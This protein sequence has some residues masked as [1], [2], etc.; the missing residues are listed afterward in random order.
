MTPTCP[1]DNTIDVDQSSFWS[2][3]N[4]NWDEHRIGWAIAGGCAMLTVL[5]SMVS[6]LGHC[7]NYTKPSEQRQILRILYMPPVYAVISFFS[8]RYFR[9]YTYYSL[10]ETA[11]EAITLSAFLLLLI[12]FVADTA[13]GRDA[14][15]AIERKGKRS[16]PIPFCCWK[17][18][19]TKPYFM[20]TVKWSV[21][22]YVIFRPAVSIAGIVCEVYNVLCE[23]GP[24]SIYF[25]NVY[26][27]AIDFVSISVALYGL[28]LFY[29]LTK[30]ELVGRRPMAK[31]LSIKLIVMFTF[32]QSFVFSALEGRV[33]KATEYWTA[34]NIADGLNALAICIEMVFFSVLMMWAYTVNEYKAAEDK[35]TSIWRP[36]WDSVNYWD[37]ITE[38]GGSFKFFFNYTRGASSTHSSRKMNF[39]QAFGVGG[40]SVKDGDKS[41]TEESIRLA[42]YPYSDPHNANSAS[43]VLS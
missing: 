2:S 5:I 24:Y 28:L 38:I 1:S 12:E 41:L 27:E 9:S 21:L 20:Y 30:E 43:P 39:A 19:P 15:K 11:Y 33:I 7:R 22:Q 23:S 40:R 6:V 25:A 42:P 14:T 31:F 10:I 37:F 35:K 4:L 26:L 29:G 18:R 16:L 17:Y 36:L 34:A 32:Y 3:G 8:Y 13:A